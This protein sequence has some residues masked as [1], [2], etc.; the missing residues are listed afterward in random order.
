MGSQNP[1]HPTEYYESTS[2]IPSD[3]RETRARTP[4]GILSTLLLLQGEHRCRKQLEDYGSNTTADN[5][6]TAPG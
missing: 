2:I 3:C 1:N 6:W 5:A 4:T